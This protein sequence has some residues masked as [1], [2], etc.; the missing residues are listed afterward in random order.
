MLTFNS[1]EHGLEAKATFQTSNTSNTKAN[2][3]K[4]LKKIIE[5]LEGR[6]AGGKHF[7][8]VLYVEFT[9]YWLKK[10]TPSGRFDCYEF[11]PFVTR[12]PNQK[13]ADLEVQ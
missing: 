13:N 7:C 11:F 6:G 1:G 5:L 9:V 3:F 12:S 2:K 8:T 10:N 4:F